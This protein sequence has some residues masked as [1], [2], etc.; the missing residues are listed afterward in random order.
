[1]PS[2]DIPFFLRSAHRFFMSSDNRLRPSLLMPPR[3]LPA[4]VLAALGPGFRPLRLPVAADPPPTKAAIALTI[5]S[6]SIFKSATIL[7]ISN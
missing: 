5:R 1:L 6:L 2:F 3:R 7:S 4:V